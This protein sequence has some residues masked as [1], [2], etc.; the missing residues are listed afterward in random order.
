MGWASAG[1][2]FDPIA[3]ALIDLQAPDELKRVLLTDLIGRLRAEDWDTEDY[4]LSLFRHD[5]V[6]VAAFAAN[7]VM[8]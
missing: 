8:L 7:G 3:Q 5:P 4:S 1:E 2:I 6:I